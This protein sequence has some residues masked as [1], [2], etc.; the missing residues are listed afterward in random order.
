[1]NLLLKNQITKNEVLQKT[2][3]I[4]LYYI[5]A[6]ALRYYILHVKPDFF[7]NANLFI[8]ILL[9]GIGPL[10]GGLLL[11]KVFKRKNELSLFSIGVWKTII[12]FL[13]PVVLFTLVGILNIGQPYYILGPKI[14]IG[15]IIYGLFEEYGWRGYLQSEL[16]FLKNFPKYFIISVLWFAWHLNFSLSLDNL[17]FFGFCLLGSI[18]IGGVA[19]KTKSLILVALFHSFFNLFYI[20][21]VLEGITTMQ[22]IVILVISIVA[23]IY[24]MFLDGRKK[25]LIEKNKITI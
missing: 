2:G 17:I 11:I 24:V 19:T 12:V 4:L 15:A 13:V 1:M 16:S 5:I 25:R 6:V 3:Y 8:Q 10:F 23:I 18:G 7:I 9:E 21:R 14:I 20:T 22:K